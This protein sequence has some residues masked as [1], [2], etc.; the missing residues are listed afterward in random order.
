MAMIVSNTAAFCASD[1]ESTME[2]NNIETADCSWQ[3]NQPT[4]T[5]LQTEAATSFSNQLNTMFALDA[6]ATNVLEINL[7]NSLLDTYSFSYSYNALVNTKPSLVFMPA[8]GNFE[9]KAN[10]NRKV[11]GVFEDFRGGKGGVISA[12]GIFNE[13]IIL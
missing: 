3:E 10:T 11:S 12:H 9:I 1:D 5:I 7:M 4:D 6:A 8:N 13:I 2:Q